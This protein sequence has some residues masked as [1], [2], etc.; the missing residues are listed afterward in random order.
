MLRQTGEDHKGALVE[1]QQQLNAGPHT[2]G[3]ATNTPHATFDVAQAGP[4]RVGWITAHYDS[5]NPSDDVHQHLNFETCMG[6]LET[7]ITRFQIS[8]GEDVALC[9]FPN[10]N[11]RLVQSNKTLSFGSGNEVRAV[12]GP[13]NRLSFTGAPVSFA[14]GQLQVD[15]GIVRPTLFARKTADET[16]TSSLGLQNDDDLTVTLQPNAVYTFT[17]FLNWSS[18]RNADFKVDWTVPAGTSILWSPDAFGTL[19]AATTASPKQ[20]VETDVPVALGGVG[21]GT[22]QAMAATGIVRTG[23]TG[24]LLTLRWAQNSAN[25]LPTTVY[26]DSFVQ[27]TRMT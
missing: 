11:V 23:G 27:L 18:D 5:P 24:G 22:R 17:L 15:G 12:Y 21:A 8:W 20:S 10:S 14:V 13:S 25:P 2:M 6:D 1:F 9:S 19:A 4:K 3:V 26:R 7:L 16:V